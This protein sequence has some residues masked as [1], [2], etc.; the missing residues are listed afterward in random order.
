IDYLQ[1]HYWRSSLSSQADSSF[2]L[3]NIMQS[4]EEARTQLRSY[5]QPRLVWEVALLKYACN[6]SKLAE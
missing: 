5:V 2:K 1:S 3:V 6:F 4:L